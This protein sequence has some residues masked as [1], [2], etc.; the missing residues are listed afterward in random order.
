[1]LIINK[2]TKAQAVTTPQTL[3]L[4]YD[5]TNTEQAFIPTQKIR[6]CCDTN[7]SRDRDLQFM[8]WFEFRDGEIRILSLF[9]WSL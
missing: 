3:F 9:W 1:V 8:H 5:L 2:L 4:I 7:S 6:S